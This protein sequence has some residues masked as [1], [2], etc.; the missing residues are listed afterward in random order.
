MADLAAYVSSQ[1]DSPVID[2]TGLNELFQIKTG[3]WQEFTSEPSPAPGMP[4]DQGRAASILTIFKEMGLK[5]EPQR[6]L[7][8][9]FTVE[10]VRLYKRTAAIGCTQGSRRFSYGCWMESVMSQPLRLNSGSMRIM[11]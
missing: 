1:T 8:E 3:G 2:K 4:A 7:I 11:N 6:A 10:S 5:L 9:N